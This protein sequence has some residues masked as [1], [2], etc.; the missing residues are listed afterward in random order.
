MVMAYVF[1]LIISMAFMAGLLAYAVFAIIAQWKLFEKAGEE[2]WKSIIPF[3]NSIKLSEIA[4]GNKILG[5]LWCVVYTV[6]IPFY[7]A[8]RY[9]SSSVLTTII[10][11][12]LSLAVYIVTGIL[13]F[14]LAKA[15]GKSDG[16]SVA[17]FF[18]YPIL[19]IALGYD[20]TIEY[21]GPLAQN[22]ADL[23][24]Y[25]DQNNNYY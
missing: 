23:Q 1:I 11:L 9:G 22:K 24:Y 8:N 21:S 2:G 20:N 4:T 10:T 3:Y 12:L 18:L 17:M 15:F 19:V 7:M 25:D 6:Y 13:Y 16:W 14:K 5:I